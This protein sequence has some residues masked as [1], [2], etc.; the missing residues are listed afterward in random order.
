MSV[1]T[2]IL[3]G[4]QVEKWLSDK[5]LIAVIYPTEEPIPPK[6]IIDDKGRAWN[7]IHS[8][9]HHGKINRHVYFHR[10]TALIYSYSLVAGLVEP[11]LAMAVTR[12]ISLNY[13]ALLYKF[14]AL[15]NIAIDGRV[16][17]RRYT[18]AI[19]KSLFIAFYDKKE[20]IDTKGR[21]WT[22]IERYGKHRAIFRYARVKP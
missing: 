16:M 3:V 6:T 19:A 12:T 8:I 20:V 10:P 1:T 5:E 15:H 4:R 18:T 2:T 11:F 17:W 7:Y 14:A 21:V 22:P 9:T 13:R